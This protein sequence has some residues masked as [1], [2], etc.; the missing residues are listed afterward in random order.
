MLLQI[1]KLRGLFAAHLV[2]A[3]P[4][5]AVRLWEAQPTSALGAML[6]TAGHL[7]VFVRGTSRSVAYRAGV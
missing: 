2:D 1:G 4:R 5:R 6:Q 7:V 3:D